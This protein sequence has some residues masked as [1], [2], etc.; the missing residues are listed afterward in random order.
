LD[1]TKNINKSL[2]TFGKKHTQTHTQIDRRQAHRQTGTHT[3]ADRHRQT[4]IEDRHRQTETEDIRKDTQRD[5]RA[6]A[7][8]AA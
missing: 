4:E 3:H 1:E 5:E 2:S 7:S 6:R 8:R